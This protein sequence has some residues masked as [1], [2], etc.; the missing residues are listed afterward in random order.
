MRHVGHNSLCMVGIL[1]DKADITVHVTKRNEKKMNGKKT[2]E[3]SN[4]SWFKFW[5]NLYLAMKRAFK[6]NHR[7]RTNKYVICIHLYKKSG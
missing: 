6:T 2:T 7:P 4:C 1:A 5:L 3:S